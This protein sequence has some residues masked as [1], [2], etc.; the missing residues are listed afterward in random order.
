L[1]GRLTKGSTGHAKTTCTDRFSRLFT[2][3]IRGTFR[4]HVLSRTGS[5]GYAS[6]LQ[7]IGCVAGSAFSQ[8]INCICLDTITCLYTLKHIIGRTDHG[9]LV[10]AIETPAEYD[11]GVEPWSRQEDA[12]FSSVYFLHVA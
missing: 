4:V 10:F 8:E 6:S 12:S 5:A 3:F 2:I 7:S 11:G 1:H 9:S